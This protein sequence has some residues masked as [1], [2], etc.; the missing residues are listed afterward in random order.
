MRENKKK[1][2]YLIFTLFYQF[3]ICAVLFGSI[4]ALKATNSDLYDSIRDSYYLASSQ[5]NITVNDVSK[6]I[7]KEKNSTVTEPTEEQKAE[8]VSE[9]KEENTLSATIE[10]TEQAKES[11]ATPANVSVNSY[12]LN[13]RMFLPVKG[14]VTSEFGERQHPIT[15]EEKY[16]AGIDI[17]AAT[18]TPIRAAFDGE[19]IVATYDEWNGNYLKIKHDGDILTVYCHCQKLNVKKGD[20]VKAGDVVAYIGSTG[21]S[22]G[23]HL[24]FEL[25]IANISYDPKA[26]L[27]EAINAV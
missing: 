25:R 4:Y 8:P 7:E 18:G 14:T 1:K 21:S 15:N 23:P 3:L 26:A 16:H 27:D 9:K 24:H 19:V 11:E 5:K 17:A 22:T 2:D 10:K 12:V 13:Q 6:Y 20:I